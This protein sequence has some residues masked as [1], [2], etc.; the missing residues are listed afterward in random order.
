[1]KRPI[2]AIA[3]FLILSSCIAT[4]EFTTADVQGYADIY[5]NRIDQAPSVLKG[6]LGDESI[7]LEI[8]GTNGSV[9]RTGLVVKNAR[10]EDVVEGGLNDST[11]NVVTTESAINKIKGSDDPVAEFQKE[12][13]LGQVRIEGTNPISSGK[14]NALLS[15]TDVIRFFYNIFFGQRT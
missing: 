14:V 12:K 8:I 1:M 11:I 9:L 4:A 13:D 10:I 3:I 7:N 5:N 6:I 2:L 15:S